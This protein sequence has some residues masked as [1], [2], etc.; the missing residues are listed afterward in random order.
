MIRT[1]HPPLEN[2]FRFRESQMSWRNVSIERK[3]YHD[4]LSLHMVEE[5]LPT[6][7]PLLPPASIMMC[8][9]AFALARL[10]VPKIPLF[11]NLVQQRLPLPP[12]LIG[13]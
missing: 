7:F 1:G 11:T 4:C 5:P 12:S 6:P 10:N 2:H 9:C 13:P 3:S 8:V